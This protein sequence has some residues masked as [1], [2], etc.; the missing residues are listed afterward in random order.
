MPPALIKP[1]PVAP[2][3][4][5]PM[6]LFTAAILLAGMFECKYDYREDGLN[7]IAKIP[8]SAQPSSTPM[9]DGVRGFIKA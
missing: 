1:D 6:Q 8:K 3:G 9:Q 5:A 7:L 2:K 4:R